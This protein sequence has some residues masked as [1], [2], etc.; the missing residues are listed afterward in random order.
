[1]RRLYQKEWQGIQFDEFASLSS[2][3]LAD[4]QFYG[5]FYEAFF[6]RYRSWDDIDHAWRDQKKLV[7]DFLCRLILNGKSGGGRS[8]SV[9]CGLGYI[10]HCLLESGV[11]CSYLD[12]HEIAETPLRFIRQE[13]PDNNIYIGTIPECLPKEYKYRL[14]YLVAVDYTINRDDFVAFLGKLRD[15][16]VPD[17]RCVVITASYDG[18]TG[19]LKL[20]KIAKYGIKRLLDVLRLRSMGQFWGWIRN[21]DEF[22]SAM[23][24]AGFINIEDGFIH[25]GTEKT[26]YIS[27]GIPHK[28]QT[29]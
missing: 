27:G 16:L 17:G 3:Q 6:D 9:G 20:K 4:G 10:E 19:L 15:N 5:K 12:I 25:K 1:M 14:I 2:K 21:R 24:V 7:A 22:H 23:T 18:S 13:L 29:V 28:N 8:L 11:D 26:Y